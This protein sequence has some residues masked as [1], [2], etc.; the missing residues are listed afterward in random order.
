MN[1]RLSAMVADVEIPKF[2][3][4][5]QKF[6]DDH[7]TPAQ[8]P[9]VLLDKL[10]RAEIADAIQ[11]GMRVCLTCGSRGIRNI[12]LVVRTV[13]DFC[14]SRGAEPFAIPAM[15]SHGGA[16]AEGQ[17]QILASLGMTEETLGC[18]I[19]SS[20]DTVVVGQTEDGHDVHVDAYAANA[21]AIIVINRIKPHTSFRGVYES[22]LMKMMAIGLGKQKGAS[23][24]HSQGYKYMHKMIP[25]FGNVI[26]DHAPIAFGVGLL[27]NAFDQTAEVHALTPAEIRTEE[28][29]LL[30]RAFGLMPRLHFDRCDVLVVDEIG[31]NISGGGMDPN[32]TGAFSTPY[33]SGGIDAQNRCVLSL[34]EETHG[35]GY[36]MGGADVVSK[37]FYDALDFDKTYPNAITST[38][39][40]FAK[41]PLVMPNDRD[42]MRLCIRCSADIGPDGPKMIRIKNTL[43]LGT[44][45][46]S[47]ALLQ[48]A[49]ANPNLEILSQ[50]EALPFDEQGNLP[51]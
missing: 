44:I 23:S 8:I 12:A 10:Q 30:Q 2:A 19:L 51:L 27:E 41:L 13:A 22:G 46:I 34:T 25:A 26:L 36:G 42:A 6:P 1:D 28:P 21:D 33:A 7:L 29:K 31:K 39:I 11:P 49:A 16:T 9:A 32:I 5:R 38:A 43:E 37:R 47:E 48:E 40:C 18:P 3:T 45:Q 24:C 35:S 4:V 14:K 17:R 20:M 50:P 15:G